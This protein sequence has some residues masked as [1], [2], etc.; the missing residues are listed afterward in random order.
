MSSPKL[1]WS[2]MSASIRSETPRRKWAASWTRYQLESHI[3]T[4]RVN[5]WII[6]SHV[7]KDS[8]LFI[9]TTKKKIHKCSSINTWCL[10]IIRFFPFLS[11]IMWLILIRSNSPRHQFAIIARKYHQRQP[12]CIVWLKMR[13]FVWNAIRIIMDQSWPRSIKG[14]ISIKNLKSLD[15]VTSTRPSN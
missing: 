15:I 6:P 10:R 11:L 9:S 4:V 1:E 3:A 12:R 13:I 2:L 7:L 8:N 14:S 5:F